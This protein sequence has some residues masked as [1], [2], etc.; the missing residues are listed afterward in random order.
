MS[1]TGAPSTGSAVL[2]LVSRFGVNITYK[3]VIYKTVKVR[4]SSCAWC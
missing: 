1:L 3:T 4:Q 2:R